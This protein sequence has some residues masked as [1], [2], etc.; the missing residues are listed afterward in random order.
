MML[1][2]KQINDGSIPAIDMKDGDVAVITRWLGGMY[3]GRIVQRHNNDLISLG[4]I[5]KCRWHNYFII[6]PHI[7]TENCVRILKEGEILVVGPSQ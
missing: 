7:S 4:A 1:Q 2:L 3:L 6:N 5:F